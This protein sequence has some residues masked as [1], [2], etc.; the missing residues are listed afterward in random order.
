MA[1]YIT[2]TEPQLVWSDSR[3]RL[4]L[5]GRQLLRRVLN[6][7]LTEAAREFEA[8]LHR[9]DLIEF[10]GADLRKLLL[11]AAVAELGPTVAG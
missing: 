9:G 6:V 1:H 8:G 2:R 7:A 5:Q 4:T 11:R 3:E 10:D